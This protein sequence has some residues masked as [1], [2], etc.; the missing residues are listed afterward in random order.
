M[1]CMPKWL[2]A[3]LDKHESWRK[4]ADRECATRGGKLGGIAADSN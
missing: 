1:A 2:R 4:K 3:G